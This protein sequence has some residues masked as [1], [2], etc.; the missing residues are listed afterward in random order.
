MSRVLSTCRLGLLLGCCVILGGGCATPVKVESVSGKVTV[1]GQPVTSGQVT[2]LPVGK[3]GGSAGLS[4]GTI[5][6]TGTYKIFTAGKEGAPAG[7]YKVTVTPSM[8]PTGDKMPT[9]PFNAKYRDPTNTPLTIEVPSTAPGGYD[10][11]LSK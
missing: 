7:K 8:V 10:L 4:A 1:G 6:E 5:D 9:T 2:F 3:E 11:K